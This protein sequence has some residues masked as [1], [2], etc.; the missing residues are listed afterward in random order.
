MSETQPLRFPGP[1]VPPRPLSR[2]ALAATLKKNALSGFS[3]NAFEDE[4]VTR[5]LFG[6]QQIVLNRPAAIRHV[7]IDNTNNYTR[8]AASIRLL[9]PIVGRGLLL[10]EGEDWKEQRRTA[11][12]AFAPRTIPLLARHIAA[13]ASG[14]VADLASD[15]SAEAEVDI[16]ARMQGLALDI[17]ARSMFSIELA[18]FGPQMREHLLRY[19]ETL[20]RPSMLDIALPP[21]IPTWR[22]LRRRLFRRR[23]LALMTRLIAARSAQTTPGAPRDLLDLLAQTTD[24]DTGRR[25]SQRRLADQVATMIVAGHA[26]SAVALFWSCY[27]LASAPSA[28]DRVAVEVAALDL[29]PE[30]AVA[31][32]PRLIYTRAVAQEALRLYP[33]A[34]V[35]MRRARAADDAGG[36]AVPARAVVI[37]SPWVL[38][39]HHRLWREPDAFDPSRFLPGATPPDRFAY[40]PFGVGPRVCIG[41]QFALTEVVLVLARLI[42]AFRVERVDDNVVVPSVDI[43]LRPDHSPPFRLYPRGHAH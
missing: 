38:H 2:R 15:A 36:I 37:I 35:I 25:F 39:R 3:Q 11:A 26:T 24:P 17:A 21:A 10:A 41:A 22:D 42:Q 1:P 13:A 19:A 4:I 40:L 27:L 29:G 12:P 31:A 9:Y 20:G 32:L 33:P 34:H 30:G 6:H 16:L 14:L 28:Q 18:E 23:W 5:R 7:L 8:T 43:T